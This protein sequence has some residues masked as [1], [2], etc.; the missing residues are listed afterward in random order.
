MQT[1]HQSCCASLPM[2]HVWVWHSSSWWCGGGGE[3]RAVSSLLNH[4]SAQ[5]A[6][7]AR[8][9]WPGQYC[10]LF[11]QGLLL[12]LHFSHPSALVS[13]FGGKFTYGIYIKVMLLLCTKASPTLLQSNQDKRDPIDAHGLWY[14][15][16]LQYCPLTFS[17]ETSISYSTFHFTWNAN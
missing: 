16:N 15:T 14:F 5:V 9:A 11:D 7:L 3:G 10:L 13:P 6:L 12:P 2:H 4:S 8:Q 17:L 1:I